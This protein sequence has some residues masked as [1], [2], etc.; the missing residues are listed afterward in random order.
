[1]ILKM[2]LKNVIKAGSDALDLYNKMVEQAIPWDTFES[3]IQELR[4]ARG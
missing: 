4:S 2:I 3:Y 1:M